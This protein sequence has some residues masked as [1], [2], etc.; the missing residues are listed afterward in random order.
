MN[1][2]SGICSGVR[3]RITPIAWI[4]RTVRKRSSSIYIQTDGAINPEIQVECLSIR[5]GS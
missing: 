1:L 2:E 5:A 3:V 4:P